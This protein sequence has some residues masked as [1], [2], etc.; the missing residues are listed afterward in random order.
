MAKEVWYQPVIGL[1]DESQ[2]KD[3]HERGYWCSEAHPD[4]DE[5]RRI[6][7]KQCSIRG[8]IHEIKWVNKLEF[9]TVTG[10]PC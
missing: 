6:A 5:A 10:F 1:K 3:K 2:A 4:E 8:D 9:C 7:R